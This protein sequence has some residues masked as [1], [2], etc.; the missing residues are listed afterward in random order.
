MWVITGSLL[1]R[2][3]CPVRV[4]PYIPSSCSILSSETPGT[5]N[6][7]PCRWPTGLFVYTN[8]LKRCGGKTRRRLL[9]VIAV[10]ELAP[11]FDLTFDR[12]NPCL[13]TAEFFDETGRQGP[14][15]WDPNA[16]AE[17]AASSLYFN[18]KLWETDLW[19]QQKGKYRHEQRPALTWETKCIERRKCFSNL[20]GW[21]SFGFEGRLCLSKGYVTVSFSLQF[22]LELN[23]LWD[24]YLNTGGRGI[25]ERQVS[26]EFC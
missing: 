13:Q 1:A 22:P 11:S 20:L 26:T 2:M 23:L 21:N 18:S 4:T 12:L 10:L 24:C 16:E 5:S 19:E 14:A 25:L 8:D 6:H 7:L 15:I 9:S 3:Q 17:T